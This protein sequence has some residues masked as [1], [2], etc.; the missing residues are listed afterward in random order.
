MGYSFNEL[1]ALAYKSQD[2][3]VDEWFLMSSPLKPTI[4]VL[5][6]ML[7][8]VR[9]GPS[10]MKNRAP[11]NLKS[12]LRVYNIFQMIYNSCLFIVIWNEM[13]VIRSLRN[14]DCKIE[15]TDERLLECL[16]IGWLYLINKMVDLLDTIFMILRK[17]NEQ[18]SFLHVYH[19]SIMIFLSWFGI[20]YMGGNFHVHIQ[21]N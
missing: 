2:S 7:I 15:R 6:Y 14:D 10:L 13:Q 5:A 8:A 4:L 20:K 21:M 17:K 3:R 11:Y 18:I 9:I 16:S 12:T 1:V 19:H